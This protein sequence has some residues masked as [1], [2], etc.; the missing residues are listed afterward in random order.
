VA[1][2]RPRSI[3]NR[4]SNPGFA[5]T[6][7]LLTRSGPWPIVDADV[8]DGEIHM[9]RATFTPIWPAVGLCL[10]LTAGLHPPAAMGHERITDDPRGEGLIPNCGDPSVLNKIS[11]RFAWADRNTWHRGLTI[12]AIDLT[13]QRA[14]RPRNGNGTIGRRYC[15]ARALL[16][17]GRRP[18]VHY[19]I[20]E[21]Q[22]FASISWN[23]EFCIDG[24]DRWR[25]YD[26]WCRTVRP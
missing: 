12:T 8:A 25:V 20:E 10:A 24:L 21:H 14:Y 11:G 4:L 23:V 19:L 6:G 9:A 5:L 22:G 1:A 26:G 2:D 3:F 13:R 18:H 15:R 17:N 16:S 7:S